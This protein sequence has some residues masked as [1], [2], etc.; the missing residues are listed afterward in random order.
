MIKAQKL[1]DMIVQNL[2]VIVVFPIVSQLLD[3]CHDLDCDQSKNPVIK[4]LLV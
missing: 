3:M 4:E 2:G 1:H